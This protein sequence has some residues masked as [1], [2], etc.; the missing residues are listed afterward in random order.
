MHRNRS[1]S[2]GCRQ[3]HAIFIH[4]DYPLSNIL[5]LTRSSSVRAI[6]H[7]QNYIE[8]SEA[9][10]HISADIPT[11]PSTH[12]RAQRST[13]SDVNIKNYYDEDPSTHHCRSHSLL[14]QQRNIA[15]SLSLSRLSAS[16]TVPTRQQIDRNNSLSHIESFV[17]YLYSFEHLTQQPLVTRTHTLHT[18]VKWDECNSVIICALDVKRR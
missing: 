8:I 18:L 13:Y 14:C 17:F 7:Q 11:A 9:T 1:R 10:Y 2:W 16:C 5:H 4:Y 12:T 6:A 3:P 15:L